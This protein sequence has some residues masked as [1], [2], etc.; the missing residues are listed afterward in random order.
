M[1]DNRVRRCAEESIH[2]YCCTGGGGTFARRIKRRGPSTGR[3]VA[4]TERQV[5]LIG[6]VSSIRSQPT[7]VAAVQSRQQCKDGD[8]EAGASAGS[9]D[10]IHMLRFGGKHLGDRQQTHARPTAVTLPCGWRECSH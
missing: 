9:A 2:N 3:G 10:T 8:E 5:A 4:G 6:G 7:Q 1:G